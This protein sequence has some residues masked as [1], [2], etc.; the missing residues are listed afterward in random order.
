MKKRTLY[1]KD[2]EDHWSEEPRSAQYQEFLT[3]SRKSFS[4]DKNLFNPKDRFNALS[5]DSDL[6]NAFNQQYK[7]LYIDQWLKLQNGFEACLRRNNPIRDNIIDYWNRE[8]IIIEYFHDEF[9]YN[10]RWQYYKIEYEESFKKNEDKHE[11]LNK[12]KIISLSNEEITKALKRKQ[13]GW[14][15]MIK[16]WQDH[17]NEILAG[18][19]KMTKKEWL[20]TERISE[21]EFASAE[22]YIR[23]L[24]IIR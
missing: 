10:E 21:R 13:M 19:A 20:N 7:L 23:S 22:R 2:Y 4:T 24:R 15:T 11:I 18:Y 5:G 8:I 12:I 3:N 9:F 6:I 17:Q 14:K 1:K 16:D